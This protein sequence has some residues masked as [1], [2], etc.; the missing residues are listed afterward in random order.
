MSLRFIIDGYNLVHNPDF[1]AP[2][3]KISVHRAL[4]VLIRH[5][6]LCGKSS[7]SVTVVWD[8]FAPSQM[9]RDLYSGVIFV[10]SSDISADD[11]IRNMLEEAENTKNIIV[12]SDDKQVQASARLFKAR[13]Q[14]I[15]EFLKPAAKAFRQKRDGASL[16][17]KL[18]HAQQCQINKELLNLWCEK[19][20]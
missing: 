11:K 9:S 5:Y 7:N 20:K 8:G 3:G 18:T 15:E 12:V 13:Y 4:A 14:R 19:K 1:P 6:N 17:D 16:S 10:F 2:D